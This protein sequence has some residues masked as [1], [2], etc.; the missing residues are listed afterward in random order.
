[1]RTKKKEKEKKVEKA[2]NHMH[3][4]KQK[5]KEKHQVISSRPI[6]STPIDLKSTTADPL[7]A[8]HRCSPT[9]L[10]RRA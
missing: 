2:M 5:D 10:P 7:K 3:M 8:A 9:S 4:P 1:M 6:H